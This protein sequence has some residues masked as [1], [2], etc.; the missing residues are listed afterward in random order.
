MLDVVIIGGGI[1]GC[2]LLYALSRYKLDILLVEKEND[3]AVGSTKANSAIVHAGYDPADGTN[4]AKYNV[5]GNT[6]IKS[7]CKNLDIHYKN[8]GSLVVGFDEH[9]KATINNL[10]NRGIKNGVPGLEI[11]NC[12][13][14]K[15]MEPNI[16]SEAQFA[17]Y[18]PTAGIVSP[19]ELAQIQAAAAVESGAKIKLRTRVNSINKIQ[20]K[21]ILNTNN[22]EL[23][24]RF[25]VNAAG[26]NAGEISKMA[27]DNSV[28]IIPNKGQ[29]FLLDTSQGNLVKRVIFQCPTPKGKGVLVAPTVHGNLIVGPNAEPAK[30]EDFSTTAEGLNMVRNSAKKSVPSIDFRESIR[31]FAGL[32]AVSYTGDFVVGQSADVS[33]FFNIAGIMSPGLTAAPAIAEDMVKMLE[34][35]GLNLDLNPDYC[36][37][38]KQVRFRYLN[39]KEKAEII[40]NNPAYGQIL[41]RC[42][43]VTEGELIDALHGPIPPLSVG[44]AKRRINAGMGRCQGGFCGARVQ[45]VIARELGIPIEDVPLEYDGSYITAGDL[46]PAL[47]KEA[48]YAE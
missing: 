15:E 10:Y 21:F 11:L 36:E 43:T 20:D 41:C 44:A 37:K 13:K 14:L 45:A 48:G 1:S 25:V 18:A 9:D 7:L 30:P 16:S 26:I 29:Y 3:V 35:S 6:I 39:K 47:N 38:R 27:G 31:N 42:Q 34:K 28:K 24:A 5:R 46:K 19:W 4:M 32:R 2:S 33:G 22:G 17:L 8:T 40:K 23:T 12:Q